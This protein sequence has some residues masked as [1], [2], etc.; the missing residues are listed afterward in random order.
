MRRALCL[1]FF[2]WLGASQAP[3][4][5][6]F[7]AHALNEA[8]KLALSSG[9]LA[10]AARIFQ[11]LTD[12]DDP[13]GMNNLGLLYYTGQGVP[14]DPALAFSLYKRSADH[15]AMVKPQASYHTGM[16]YLIGEV[17]PRNVASALSYLERAATMDFG[18]AEYELGL[19]YLTEPTI[20]DATKALRL[21]QSAAVHNSPAAA[22][23]AGR[24]IATG[25]GTKA[26]IG[27]AMDY[28]HVAAD[29]G[30]P[31]AYYLLGLFAE[32]EYR[33]GGPIDA[34]LQ[35]YEKAEAAG[36]MEAASRR[37]E[38]QNKGLP[39]YAKQAEYRLNRD[40]PVG[41]YPFLV[42]SCS[43]NETYG[44]YYQAVALAD[45][46]GTRQDRFTAISMFE[47]LCL[48]TANYGC[49]EFARTA[50]LMGGSAGAAR[51][52]KAQSIFRDECGTSDQSADACYSVALMSWDDSFGLRSEAVARQYAETSCQVRNAN[53]EACQMQRHYQIQD[54]WKDFGQQNTSR[55]PSKPNFFEGLLYGLV[56]GAE[57]QSGSGNNAATQYGEAARQREAA[58]TQ[59]AIEAMRPGSRHY[60]S[61]PTVNSPGC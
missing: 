43:N 53:N 37:W 58:R 22:Y 29:L 50:L 38:M 51:N 3:A 48:D 34:A 33:E 61:C 47:K 45:G 2:I 15:P 54:S 30:V 4:Q 20:A 23:E 26:D 1:A 6:N 5:D 21:F 19:L 32:W 25:Q 31:S 24:M 39:S 27:M 55:K 60:G 17:V 36:I 9:D 28:L 16:A 59:F 49:R 44:C 52:Q 57:Q 35:W 56:V 42:K 8:G 41:A 7:D 13:N 14:K 18:P 10:T 11:Q 12:A 40:D 46:R